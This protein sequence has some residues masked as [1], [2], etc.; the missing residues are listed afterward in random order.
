MIRRDPRNPDRWQVYGRRDG[1]KVYVG[2]RDSE[3]E[4]KELEQEHVVTQRKIKRG[5]LPPAFNERRTFGEAAKVWLK[6]LENT[7]ARSYDAYKQ[8][9]DLYFVAFANVPLADIKRT[10]IIA[11]RD[12]QAQRLSAASVNTNMGALSSAFSFFV[13]RAWIEHNPCVRVKR[14]KPD[15]RV[16]PW[17]QSNEM[18]TK[19]LAELAYKWRTIVAVLVGT[20]VRL[21]EALYLRWDDVDIEHRL[22]TVHRGAK[23]TTKSGKARRVPIFDSVLAVLKQMKLER[24]ENVYLWPGGKP[25]KP[26]R[27]PSVRKPFK[28]ALDRLGYPKELRLH[29]LRHTFASLYL[30]DGGDIFRLSRILGHNTVAITERTYAHLKPDAFESDYGRVAFRMPSEPGNVIALAS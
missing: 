19:L 24:G 16:F 26:L 7:G 2:T 5:E 27:Q 1:K 10:D 4:A 21:D 13:D 22:I 17:L 20:G 15:G 18:I 25:G 8:R 11:W 9:V 30:V 29:D 28:L 6:T 14:L 3:R 12:D 23:G